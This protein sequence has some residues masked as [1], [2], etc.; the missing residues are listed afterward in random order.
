MLFVILLFAAFALYRSIR[1][2][3]ADGRSANGQRVGFAVILFLLIC[4]TLSSFA[5]VFTTPTVK[6]AY[7]KCDQSEATAYWEAPPVTYTSVKKYTTAVTRSTDQSLQAVSKIKKL[8]QQADANPMSLPDNWCQDMMQ[9][10]ATIRHTYHTLSVI[11]PPLDSRVV[12]DEYVAAAKLCYESVGHSLAALRTDNQ[13]EANTAVTFTNNCIAKYKDIKFGK[14]VD[15]DAPHRYTTN[16]GHFALRYDP[17]IWRSG[18]D[19]DNPD[20][21]MALRHASGDAF[22]MVIA[23]NLQIP[24]D[25]L[26]TAVVENMR[27]VSPDVRVINQTT[28]TI[29]GNQFIALQFDATIEGIKL[30][31]YGYVYSGPEGSLQVLGG[32][33]ESKFDEYKPML[34]EVL[35]GIEIL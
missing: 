8:M 34:D 1:T 21:E 15:S 9:Q 7:T 24:V 25:E 32:A 26:A 11:T 4:P 30:R 14:L 20:I 23:E 5:R 19:P 33:L 2:R 3:Q 16:A 17:G 10:F 27:T 28:M 18:T 6:A 29:N 13:E 31:Y 35:T 12:H 22:V